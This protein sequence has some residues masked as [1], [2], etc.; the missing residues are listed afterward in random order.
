VPGVGQEGGGV[1]ASLG[2]V[3]ERAVAKLV[4]RPRPA[5][6]DG[7]G[8][9]KQLSGPTVRQSCPPRGWVEVTGW[10]LHA[11]ATVCEED[12]AGPAPLE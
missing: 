12:R 4:Q 8:L 7:G 11:G 10:E 2:G 5:R 1:G 6:A 3:G 9:L